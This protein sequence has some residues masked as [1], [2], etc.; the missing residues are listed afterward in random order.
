MDARDASIFII[1]D[2]A[3]V[4]RSLERLVRSAGLQVESFPS[5]QA[6]LERSPYPGK[7]CLILDVRMPGLT[8]PDLHEQMAQRGIDL[9]IVYLTGHG[10]VATSVR[11]MKKGAV[12][13]L[14]KPADDSVLLAT[15]DRA[16]ERHALQK[17]REEARVRSRAR[18][19]VLSAREREV[20]EYVIAGRLNK[21]IAFDLNISEKTVKAHRG[22]VM[23]KVQVRSVA[24]LVRLC[25]AA[26][27]EP[28]RQA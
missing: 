24:D 11:A 12:D 7:G 27:V 18:L 6:F 22:R 14:L 1:D 17:M 28:R 10:D 23:E 20:M 3:E 15:I 25:E 8:G 9:P 2:M 5:A 21:Q 13:F 4:R 19:S 16:L 26:G